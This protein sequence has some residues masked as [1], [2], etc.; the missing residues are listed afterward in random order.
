MPVKPLRDRNDVIEML[1][2]VNAVLFLFV[3]WSDY[4]RR[5]RFVFEQAEAGFASQPLN[6]SVSWWIADVSTIELPISGIIHQ[7]LT[8]RERVGKVRMFPIVATGNGSA[9]WMRSGEIVDFAPNALRLESEGMVKRTCV[10]FSA[11][12]DGGALE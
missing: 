1:A 8:E 6:A 11:S 3:N 10:V 5:G 7:W 9:V 12:P 2:S 4:A